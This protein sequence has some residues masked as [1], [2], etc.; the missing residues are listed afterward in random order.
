M[1]YQEDSESTL[2]IIA[3]VA[4][5][6]IF[7]YSLFMLFYGFIDRRTDRMIVKAAAWWIV[8]LLMINSGM[9]F[10]DRV[11][12]PLKDGA[13]RWPGKKDFVI[14]LCIA[15]VVLYILAMWDTI[16]EKRRERKEQYGD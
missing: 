9:L 6:L 1:D 13:F 7:V 5:I 10:F 16:S 4:G 14:Y 2:S 11:L 12:E 15:Y 8:F 3:Q